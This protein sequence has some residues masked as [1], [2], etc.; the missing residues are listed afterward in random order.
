MAN[1]SNP[2][3]SW[4]L[5]REIVLSRVIYAPR[6]KV[7]EAWTQAEHLCHWFGPTGFTIE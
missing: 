7:F 3:D 5:D 1:Q 6:T 2:L 4:A